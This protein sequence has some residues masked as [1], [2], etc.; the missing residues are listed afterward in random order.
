MTVADRKRRAACAVL[1]VLVLGA[2]T[3][4]AG[5]SSGESGSGSAPHDGS[6]RKERDEFVNGVEKDLAAARDRVN[7]MKQDIRHATGKAR[8]DLQSGVKSLE[9]QQSTVRSKLARLKA[10]AADKWTAFK[11]GVQ[12][13]VEKLKQSLHKHDSATRAPAR[14]VQTAD[15]G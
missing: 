3:A 2:V 4:R 7:Q 14:E 5:E 13:E 11:E 10:A 1:A 12:T 8:A 9:H 15:Q 6:A